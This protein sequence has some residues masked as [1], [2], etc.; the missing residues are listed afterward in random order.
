MWTFHDTM[1]FY[2][3]ALEISNASNGSWAN[4]VKKNK[5]KNKKDY[6]IINKNVKFNN[7]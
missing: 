1:S 5:N 2:C 4:G 7:A 3:I 6:L